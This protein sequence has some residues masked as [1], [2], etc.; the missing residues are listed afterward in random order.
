MTKKEIN[1]TIL[2]VLDVCSKKYDGKAIIVDYTTYMAEKLAAILETPAA[3]GSLSFSEARA[4]LLPFLR[5]KYM[6]F[7]FPSDGPIWEEIACNGDVAM[8]EAF[9]KLKAVCEE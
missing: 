3:K 9:D 5:L 4:M 7:G 1:N 6:A 8:F 2:S